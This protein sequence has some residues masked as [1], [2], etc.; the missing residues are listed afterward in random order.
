VYNQLWEAGASGKSAPVLLAKPLREEIIQEFKEDEAGSAANELT[1][2]E[3]K[4]LCLDMSTKT[5]ELIIDQMQNYKSI[6]TLIIVGG[7]NGSPVNL[8]DLFDRAKN[9]PLEVLYVINFKQYVKSIPETIVNFKKLTEL[10]LFNNSIEK[11]PLAI[12]SLTSLK[13]LYLDINPI[14]TI[15]P[16]I[17]TLTSLDTLGVAKTKIVDVELDKIKKSLPNCIILKQ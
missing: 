7:K 10:G 1:L 14:S 8:N 6:S 11:L 13:N 9:Y 17:N 2:E 12:G 4:T 16:A 5:I 15:T 3:T